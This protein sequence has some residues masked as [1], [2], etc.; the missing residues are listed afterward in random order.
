MSLRLPSAENDSVSCA[1][2][3]GA[4]TRTKPQRGAKPCTRATRANSVRQL[5][6]AH[7]F[8]RT[9]IAGLVHEGLATAQRSTITVSPARDHR[10]GSH[11]D[12][13][14][15]ADGARGLIGPEAG[16]ARDLASRG[17]RLSLS[18]R[19]SPELN[20]AARGQCLPHGREAGIVDARN[21]GHLQGCHRMA[22]HRR[23]ARQAGRSREG[24]SE[25]QNRHVAPVWRGSA[26]LKEVASRSILAAWPRRPNLPHGQE[27]RTCRPSTGCL[28]ATVGQKAAR[29][30]SGLRLLFQL[31]PV[32]TNRRRWPRDECAPA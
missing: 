30:A 31:P 4:S 16:R 28:F 32:R 1:P 11:Q 8:D 5:V 18:L 14:C 13:R 10:G 22:R 25:I 9:M 6:L 12:H 21:L 26:L 23:S 29:K 3:G 7:G 17:P 15:G 2:H 19:E 24:C 20:Y 27:G